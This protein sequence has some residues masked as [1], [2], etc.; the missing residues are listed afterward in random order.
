MNPE[1]NTA[2]NNGA[3][4]W[5]Y[6]AVVFLVTLLVFLPSVWNGFVKYD[7]VAYVQENPHV[8]AGM[9]WEGVKWAFTSRCA[10]FWYPLTMLSHMV[11]VQLFGLNAAGHHAHNVLLH[12]LNAWLAFLLF[13]WLFGPA[14]LAAFLALL[15]SLHP[16][17]VESVAWIAERKDL[18]SMAFFLGTLLA[19]R[20]WAR[21][22]RPGDFLLVALL[23]ICGLLTK[24][25]LVTLPFVMLL[26]DWWPL[27]R[28]TPAATGGTLRSGGRLL[29]EKAPFFALAGLFA[30]I[31]MHTAAGSIAGEGALPLGFRVGNALVSCVR[32]LGLMVWPAGLNVH[33]PLA[34]L[35][36]WAVLGAAL[37][38]GVATFWTVRRAAQAP[39]ALTGWF[40]YLVTL[41]PVLGLVQSGS[42]ALA[43]RFVY[44]PGLGLLILA[45]WGLS[46]LLG[47]ERRLAG[48]V[49]WAAAVGLLLVLAG[50]TL[51]QIGFWRDDRTLFARA[52]AL[53]PRDAVARANYG[54]A[55][56]ARD[57]PREGLVHLCEAVRLDPQ[58]GLAWANLGLARLMLGDAVS[59]EA[60]LRHALA[61][62]EHQPVVRDNLGGALLAQGRGVEARA[63]FRAVARD[64]PRDVFSHFQLGVMAQA[65][66]DAR[67]ALLHFE[68]VLRLDPEHRESAI[69]AGN[70]YLAG[71]R[72]DEAC[73]VFGRAEEVPPACAAVR[74]GLGQACLGRGD[75]VA[76]TV[77]L[78]AAIRLKP[79]C[80]EARYCLGVAYARTG[81]FAEAVR[82]LEAVT[83]QLDPRR[84]E[85]WNNL[86]VLYRRQGDAI[87]A[88]KCFREALRLD[89]D[90]SVARR[91]LADPA[92][93]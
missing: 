34:V 7:D 39:A 59:A 87:G 6:G 41:L 62:G 83:R 92:A 2:M 77:A 30:L 86:G 78:E 63:V 82:A 31:T 84:A 3:N 26:L 24:S 57:R 66:G 80:A 49:T 43:D 56:V 52:V 19:Y 88:E 67:T 13:R 33:Y 47:R 70:L 4:A 18:L 58:I 37:G 51:R 48:W 29:L 68:T 72:W 65:E 53:Y 50:L 17:R 21:S 25:M 23:M 20:R 42:Q 27:R 64:D 12:A 28:W 46:R 91:N 32:Y 40:W 69:R 90:F 45:G 74:L 54:A 35:P 14:P 60:S 9:T 44:I 71:H 81:R 11:D 38:L 75:P 89:P 73:R 15:F 22:R 61:L 1:D 55:L 36:G 10:S 93:R 8:A 85:A 5:R 79:A 16:L 76:A